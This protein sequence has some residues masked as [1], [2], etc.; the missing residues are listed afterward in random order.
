[1]PLALQECRLHPLVE[2]TTN[3]FQ[4]SLARQ[5]VWGGTAC[6]PRERWILEGRPQVDRVGVQLARR[7]RAALESW[8]KV[9][10]VGVLTKQER[11]AVLQC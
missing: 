5:A 4:G 2:Y 10:K 6:S 7:V 9:L 3:Y 1:M 11:K 8:G